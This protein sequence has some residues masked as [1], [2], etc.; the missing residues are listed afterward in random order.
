MLLSS[1]SEGK[2][3]LSWESK[4][5]FSPGQKEA[6]QYAEGLE[7]GEVKKAKEMALK[8]NPK[9]TALKEIDDL[10]GFDIATV[11]KCLTQKAV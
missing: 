5:G 1:L 3:R 2:P 7:H 9:G 8:L 6:S 4:N 11:E 10:V